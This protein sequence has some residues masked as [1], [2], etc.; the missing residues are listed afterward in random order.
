MQHIGDLQSPEIVVIV[1]AD[2]LGGDSNRHPLEMVG[3]ARA[4][5]ITNYVSSLVYQASMHTSTQSFTK[6]D[7]MYRAGWAMVAI[8]GTC[9]GHDDQ[10]KQDFPAPQKG[11]S[12]W[13]HT[14]PRR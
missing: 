2:A 12:W 6:P 8:K 5:T 13:P 11:E 9:M 14:D 10:C 7:V 1:Y 3:R 4:N